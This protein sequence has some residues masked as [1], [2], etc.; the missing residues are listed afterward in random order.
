ML[1][2][3]CLFLSKRGDLDFFSSVTDCSEALA[4]LTFAAICLKK[5]ALVSVPSSEL[6]SLVLAEDISASTKS[7]TL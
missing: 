1:S 5:S 2:N 4:T 7:P 6:V 3:C